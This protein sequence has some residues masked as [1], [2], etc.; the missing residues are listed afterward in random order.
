MDTTS[1]HPA[2]AAFTVHPSGYVYRLI[3]LLSKAVAWRCQWHPLS[4]QCR[5]CDTQ[6]GQFIVLCTPLQRHTPWFLARPDRL[7]HSLCLAFL[8]LWLFSLFVQVFKDIYP[9]KDFMPLFWWHFD[10]FS[11][12]I[13]CTSDTLQ[14]FSIY[15]STNDFF[16]FKLISLA[17]LNYV[18]VCVYVYVHVYECTCVCM[19]EGQMTISTVVTQVLP[20]SFFFLFPF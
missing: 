15:L 18:Y 19:S 2:S 12:F 4:L 13:L 16:V 5:R 14:V 11:V 8:Q 7:T 20:F 10:T 17:T 1:S 3:V 6:S 9:L